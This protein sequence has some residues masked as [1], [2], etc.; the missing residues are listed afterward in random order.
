M[1]T[2]YEPPTAIE[3]EKHVIGGCLLGDEDAYVAF[4][5]LKPEDFYLDKHHHIFDSLL[6]IHRSGTTLDIITLNEHLDR[7]HLLSSVGGTEYL[8]EIASEVVSCA[9]MDD[10][11]RILK[12]YSTRRAWDKAATRLLTASRNKNLSNEEVA[13]IAE[14]SFSEVGAGGDALGPVSAKKCLA[15]TIDLIE[16]SHSGEIQGLQTQFPAF[17]QLMGGICA[18]DWI[19]LAGRPAVGK[20]ALAL[21][22]GDFLATDKQKNVLV[23]SLEMTK[24][25]LMQRVICRRQGIDFQL[26]RT[27]RLPRREFQKIS[28]ACR[29]LAASK[30][31]IDDNPDMTPG[32]MLA[33]AKR[34]KNK[35]G[36]DLLIVD[37]LSLMR[38]DSRTENR[39]Q[40][41]SDITRAFKK[42]A[43]KL[44]C[45]IITLVHLSRAIEARGEDAVP[46]KSDL[47]ECGS[48][49]QDADVVMAMHR[50]DNQADRVDLH[51]LK[52]RNGPE[53]VLPFTAEFQ[54]MRFKPYE[55]RDG[56]VSGT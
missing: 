39:L 31:Y 27:G 13:A 4:D 3:I 30:L 40:E 33:L 11:C 44:D 35:H 5:K 46:R 28:E 21:D 6:A 24:E 49:E 29:E 18:P 56:F 48:I 14:D 38:S 9:G 15:G 52:Q 10:H 8:F 12:D 50:P 20:T 1:E 36:L 47:R 26:L 22:I 45:P 37:N 2:A 17:N 43:K 25:Q 32:R 23:C 51:I 53:G 42:F 34:H 41:V 7:A 19:V 55:A 54:Y 16:R